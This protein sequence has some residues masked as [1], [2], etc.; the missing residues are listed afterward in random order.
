MNVFLNLFIVPK[1]CRYCRYRCTRWECLGILTLGNLPPWLIKWKHLNF[2]WIYLFTRFTAVFGKNISLLASLFNE[3]QLC[4]VSLPIP[5]LVDVSNNQSVSLCNLSVN[6]LDGPD[7]TQW[8]LT[9]Q[10]FFMKTLTLQ[11]SWCHAS[12]GP[13]WLAECYSAVL[14]HLITVE[15]VWV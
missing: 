14:Q 11:P 9:P 13:S 4:V 5:H 6:N 8:C 12:S 7:S 2:V 1:S 10:R 3:L 15:L